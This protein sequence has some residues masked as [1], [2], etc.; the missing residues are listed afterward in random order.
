MATATC[1]RKAV[2]LQPIGDRVL[3]ERDDR[4]EMTSGGIMLP[5]SAKEKVN[6]GRV[7]AVG[8]GKLDNEGRRIEPGVRAGDRV[9]FGK[10]AGDEIDLGD[11]EHEYLLVRADDILAVIDEN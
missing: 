10:Y 9:L 3:L 8:P 1:E 4:E 6:R 7:V 11:D 2:K 5:D